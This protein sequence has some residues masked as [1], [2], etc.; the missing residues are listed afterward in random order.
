MSP[1]PM[2]DAKVGDVVAHAYHKS[3]MA[4]M[5][6]QMAVSPQ[7]VVDAVDA[8]GLSKM[9]ALVVNLDRRPDRM[10]DAASRLR[11]QCPWL[12]YTRL[13]ASDGHRDI[14]SP[15]QCSTSWHTGK[16]TEYQI[17]RSKRK[18]WDDL[19]TYFV[20]ELE[21]TAG[22][23]G[24]ALSHIRAW[25]HCVDHCGEDQ[26]LLVLEDDAAPTA[27]FT[28]VLSRAMTAVPRD[29][30]LLYL[31]YSQAAE[32]RRE[33]SSDLVEAEYVWTT[34]AYIV[35]PAGARVLLSKLPVNQP[36]D[37]FMACL[38]ADRDIKAYCVSPKIVLQVEAWNVNSDVSHSD[39]ANSSNTTSSDIFHSDDKYWGLGPANANASK[40]CLLG[41]F[42]DSDIPKS[43]DRYW[44]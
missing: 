35:W 9:E 4:P 37:N 39:E 36:V 44:G 40:E 1:Q 6:P 12:K 19:D 25:Q 27:E 28:A 38:C 21:L 26:P 2:F 7:K 43:D 5:L 32:W 14:T 30:H 10:A 22:E 29:A 15:S 3:P 13:P 41:P 31:G 8:T 18:G 16:N 42:Y 34:V 20:R 24:C 33:V 23:R 17:L 11:E